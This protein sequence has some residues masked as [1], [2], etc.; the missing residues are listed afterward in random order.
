MA[1]IAARSAAHEGYH[2][3]GEM[4][5]P[6]DARGDRLAA[7]VED[8]FMDTDRREGAD[9]ASD[10]IEAAGERTRDPSGNGMPVS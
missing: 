5:K 10:L 3:G 1:A 6:L 9:V 7:E 2:L 4:L 8:Q